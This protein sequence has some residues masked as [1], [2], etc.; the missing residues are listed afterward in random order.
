M[1]RKSMHSLFK[2]SECV[3]ASAS[4]KDTERTKGQPQV[5]HQHDCHQHDKD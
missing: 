1:E 2:P 5:N 4:L 3:L